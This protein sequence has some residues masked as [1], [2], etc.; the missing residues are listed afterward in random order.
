[1]MDQEEYEANQRKRLA[2]K[3]VKETGKKYTAILREIK[4]WD[5]DRVKNL[6][7]KMLNET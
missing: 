1:M 2:K 3:L 5:F 7:E 4:T 6:L